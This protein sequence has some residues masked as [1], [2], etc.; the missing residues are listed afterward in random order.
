MEKRRYQFYLAVL[1]RH[2]FSRRKPLPREG[3][4]VGS[5]LNTRRAAANKTASDSVPTV[6][7]PIFKDS[8]E[9]IRY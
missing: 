7:K 4:G 9:T 8:D 3:L 2:V 5:N 1:T 6:G